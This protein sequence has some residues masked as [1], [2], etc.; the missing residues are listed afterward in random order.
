MDKTDS[1][2]VTI[3]KV[4]E[5]DFSI[6]TGLYEAVFESTDEEGNMI[7]LEGETKESPHSFVDIDVTVFGRFEKKGNGYVFKFESYNI[8]VVEFKIFLKMLGLKKATIESIISK[9]KYEEFVEILN[10]HFLEELTLIKGI[11]R[12]T[13]LKIVEKYKTYREMRILSENLSPLGFNI[14]DINRIHQY[15]KEEGEEDFENVS[16]KITLNPYILLKIPGF[17]FHRIDEIA[18]NNIGQIKSDT[19]VRIEEGIKHSL[20]EAAYSKGDTVVDYKTLF[21]ISSLNLETSEYILNRE[22]F[23]DALLSLKKTN[24]V[25]E[26]EDGKFILNEFMQEELEIYNRVLELLKSKQEIEFLM[27]GEEAERAISEFQNEEGVKYSESQI[28][29]LKKI[30]TSESS[31]LFI[32]GYAGTGKTTVIKGAVRIL[33]RSGKLYPNDIMVCALAG[34]AANRAKNVI[35]LPYS[36][37]IHSMIGITENKKSGKI[38]TRFNENITLPYRLIIVDESAMIDNFLFNALLKAVNGGSKIIFLGDIA[39]LPPVG[40]GAVFESFIRSPLYKDIKVEFTKIFRQSEGKLIEIA[41]EIRKNESNEIFRRK[42]IDFKDFYFKKSEEKISIKEYVDT[43]I[44]KE[45]SFYYEAVVNG[46]YKKAIESFQILS[47]IK[48]GFLGT[49]H[50][51]RL[52]QRRFFN[53]IRNEKNMDERFILMYYIADFLLADV[54]KKRIQAQKILKT[55]ETISSNGYISHGEAKKIKELTKKIESALK[56]DIYYTFEKFLRKET[57]NFSRTYGF[58]FDDDYKYL[59]LEKDRVIHLRNGDYYTVRLESYEDVKRYIFEHGITKDKIKKDKYLKNRIVKRKI[60]NG[61]IGIV[62]GFHFDLGMFVVYPFEELV[63]IYPRIDSN[64]VNLAYSITVH[65]SQ[66]QEYSKVYIPMLFSHFRF[67]DSKSLYTAIT[68][69]KDK[70]YMFAQGNMTESVISK[71]NLKESDVLLKRILSV[72]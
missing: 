10:E 38:I 68:R 12:K 23:E 61:Q 19:P 53:K 70:A 41:N 72:N 47:P 69:A 51:N 22:D 11:G 32:N 46:E 8:E 42:E 7:I 44:D 36:R 15:F 57:V 62:D 27:D 71:K 58:Y 18:L 33:L 37:T 65:K 63:A 67:L 40:Y 50:L 21:R 29:A 31:V 25:M 20:K 14:N 55:V 16:F 3:K 43:V 52:F 49:Y 24:S 59:Y 35:G 26:T 28:K 6:D 4:K 39:Q 13:A 5:Q 2:K 30:L 34:T 54:D 66:G 60:Y 1:I 9:Y 56:R 45:S 48:K 17:D 64:I